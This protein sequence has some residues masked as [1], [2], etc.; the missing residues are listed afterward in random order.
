MRDC[1]RKEKTRK[2][3]ELKIKKYSRLWRAREEKLHWKSSR[4]LPSLKGQGSD[5]LGVG[6][7]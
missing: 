2:S 5:T 7:Q 3:G 4:E 6:D 1:G